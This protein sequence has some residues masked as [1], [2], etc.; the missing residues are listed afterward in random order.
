MCGDCVHAYVNH[1][2]ASVRLW[3]LT[4]SLDH[5]Y[6]PYTALEALTRDTDT[7]VSTKAAAAIT[8]FTVNM[9]KRTK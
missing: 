8:E 6:L 3:F 2:S 4:H 5:G 9:F 7:A 1:P